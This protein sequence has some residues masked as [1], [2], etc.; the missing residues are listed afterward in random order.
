MN[1]NRTIKTTICYQGLL[2]LLA[3]LALA[4]CTSKQTPTAIPSSTPENTPTTSEAS[5]A[6]TATMAAPAT[7]LP[8]AT[9]EPTASRISFNPGEDSAVIN[10]TI[11]EHATNAYVLRAQQGQMMS[12]EITSPNNDVLLSVTGED[13]TP[14]KRYQNGPPSW[15]N[16]LPATQD[17]F[18]DAVSVG[19]AADYTLHVT[20]APLPTTS[21]G[22]GS[23]NQASRISF[24][25]GANSA[26]LNGTIAEHATNTYVLQ[27]QQGQIMSVE[28]TSPNN[29]V[30]LSVTGED[31]TPL[32][33]Y[34]N[35]PPS[36]TSQ[37][38]ATQD[39]FIDAVSVGPA[40][41][42]TLRVWVESPDETGPEQIEFAPNATS[43]SRSGAL[44]DGG[45]KEYVLAA[46]AGQ[47]M[48][49]QTTG[50]SAPVAFTIH[51]PSGLSWSGEAQGSEV[52]T[53]TAQVTLPEDGD[54][55]VTLSVP[56]G[57]GATRYDVTF[58]I[59]NG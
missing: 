32:K 13:G 45:T 33:R 56:A 38:P 6:P 58:T 51:S 36:W 1:K 48:Q 34:Q 18:I 44:P 10:G 3:L 28:I 49:V 12:V 57:A 2:I 22:N 27:A 46:S 8:T 53:Y 50:Y 21:S 35:G 11:A 24:A 55:M 19:P 9:S 20:I 7:P 40:T 23:D 17:Y 15:S 39:Y 42:Y 59:D 5:P 52:Y 25:P 43:T 47:I 29:D 31:G 14:L 37:L 16:Q 41:A 26:E 54:Y 30:L 4:G